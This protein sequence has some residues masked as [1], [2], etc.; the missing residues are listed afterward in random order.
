MSL[1]YIANCAYSSVYLASSLPLYPH[2]P[3]LFYSLNSNQQ[4]Q[5]GQAIADVVRSSCY[6]VT[7]KFIHEK[8]RQPCICLRYK[9]LLSHVFFFLL[10]RRW[11]LVMFR[12]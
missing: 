12:S 5:S 11:V 4:S 10:K 1:I 9:S 3:T 7:I 6:E 8:D 2:T